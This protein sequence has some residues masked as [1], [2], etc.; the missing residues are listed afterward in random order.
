L[1]AYYWN[2]GLPTAH[3][4]LDISLTGMYLLTEDRWYLGTIVQM[5][6]QDT[7]SAVVDSDKGISVQANV[8]RHASDGVGLAFIPGN[9]SKIAVLGTRAP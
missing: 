3:K 9:V 6:L 4:I 8:V 7:P 5:T 2:G 1:V